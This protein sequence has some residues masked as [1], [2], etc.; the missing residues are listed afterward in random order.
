[1]TAMKTWRPT[2]LPVA[3]RTDDIWFVDAAVGWAVNADGYIMKTSDGGASWIRQ[4]HLAGSYLRCIAFAD[5]DTGWVGTLHGPHRLYVTRNGGADWVH[6]ENLPA[7]APGRIC[8]L[9]APGPTTLYASGTN[10][11]NEQAGILRTRDGGATWDTMQVPD[12]ALLVD[13]CF[14]S[15][16][17]GWVVGGVNDVGHPARPT[18]R[19]DVVPGIFFTRDGGETWV[20]QVRGN[21]ASGEFP[22]GE[23]G[24]KFQKLNERVL[25]VSCENFHDGAILRSDDSG[26]S[27]RRLRLNDRQRNSNLEGIGFLDERQGWVGGWGD[28]DFTGGFSS[29]TVDGGANWSEANEIGFRLNRFR[30]IG[31]PPTVAYASGDT[32]YK[33]TDEPV[34]VA[35]LA[36]YARS[37][38]AVGEESVALPAEIPAGARLLQV[39]IWERFGRQVRRF[40]DEV[41]PAPGQRSIVWDFTDD[42][43]RKLVPGPFI[44][45]ITINDDSSSMIV[46]KKTSSTN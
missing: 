11:P 4:A 31:N 40:A 25:F 2:S 33:L 19:A 12:A 13:I 7:G 22:R 21:A 3:R 24:W 15:P 38:E 29:A 1:M 42:S 5:A 35:A 34:A 41:D 14:D 30:F 39:R 23:W 6:V 16:D 36:A 44:V 43:G 20:N 17:T 9:S 8:G 28:A 46:H 26:Q 18:Q 45:R 32:V 10:Y 27:W 37:P